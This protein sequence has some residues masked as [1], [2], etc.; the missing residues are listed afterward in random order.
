MTAI[1][2]SQYEIERN[3]PMPNETHAYIQAQLIFLLKSLYRKEFSFFSELS[4]ATSPSST[5]DICIYPK[6]KIAVYEVEAKTTDVPITTIEIQSPSQSIEQLIGKA[7]QLYFPMDVQSAWIIIPA[8]RG[9]QIFTPDEKFVLF[10]EG[11]VIDPITDIKLSIEEI[12]EE[13][14]Y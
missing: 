6:K 5:P 2:I 7:Q 3:K 14:E 11:D 1:A 9:I 13:L 4:L 12:F 10:T 8:I